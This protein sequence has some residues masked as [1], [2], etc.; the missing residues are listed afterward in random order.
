MTLFLAKT[1]PEETIVEHT[2]NLIDQYTIL[3]K[4]YGSKIDIDW[5]DL[6]LT[7]LWHD[8]GKINPQFQNKLK[9]HEQ[10]K[11][12]LHHNF[13]STILMEPAILRKKFMAQGLSKDAATIKVQAIVY[14]VNCHHIRQMNPIYDDSETIKQNI[15]EPIKPYLSEFPFADLELDEP[16]KLAYNFTKY[17]KLGYYPAPNNEDDIKFY[18]NYVKLKGLLNKID[19]AASGHYPIEI[20]NHVLAKNMKAW[21]KQPHIQ[22]KTAQQYAYDN[23]DKSIIFVAQTGIGKTEAALLWAD[24]DKT[25]FTLPLQAAINAIYDRIATAYIDNTKTDLGLL[26][27]NA[28]SVLTKDQKKSVNDILEQKQ[29]AKSLSYPLTIS[30]IDQLFKFVFYYKNFEPLYT[31]FMY[32]KIIID[33]IQAYDAALLSYLIFGLTEIQKLGGK[34]LI[35][36]ATIAP[37]VIDLMRD[38]GLD[39]PQKIETFY[40][41]SKQN[42]HN[43]QIVPDQIST[44]E[45]LKTEWDRNLVICNTV[46]KATNIYESL[47][48]LDHEFEI[49]LLHSKYIK[50][51]RKDLETQIMNDGKSSSN[52]KVIWVATQVVEA[53]LDIDFDCLFTELSELSGL[54][55]RMGR[56]HRHRNNITTKP[57][58]FIFDGGIKRPSGIGKN[59]VIDPDLFELSKKAIQQ[60]KGPINEHDKIKCINHFYTTDNIKNTEY[61]QDIQSTIAWLDNNKL[62]INPIKQ[63]ET[64]RLFRNINNMTVIPENIYIDNK[65]Q[66][67]TALLTINTPGSNYKDRFEAI[68]SINNLTIDLPYYSI[69][70]SNI[71]Y[72]S[73]KLNDYTEIPII[74]MTYN[75]NEKNK[76]GY[77]QILDTTLNQNT[78]VI[79]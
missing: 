31:T 22:L 70:R 74:P 54:F 27:S 56:C 36:S 20:N 46:K 3:K 43:I 71:I 53:S 79:F 59:N 47:I 60:L 23:K 57:N 75:Y 50:Q 66:I 28:L 78:D 33:E 62:Q 63:N 76:S 19:F 77:I 55:Q 12:E 52:K 17:I 73:L 48:A 41:E 15:I 69:S 16:K 7:C 34:F 32:S 21:A 30:T 67:E 26:H 37:Y 65:K 64:T 38:F 13:V 29:L 39:L 11:D 5:D 4:L 51:H 45:I 18:D 40:D 9:T 42:R 24:D 8:I 72:E 49:K 2:K 25:F 58:V 1:N 14:A 6:L 35:M 10:P 61:Y 44:D 68:E